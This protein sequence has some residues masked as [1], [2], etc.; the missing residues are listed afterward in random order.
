[1]VLPV[2]HAIMGAAH[3]AFMGEK[4]VAGRA[5]GCQRFGL[6]DGMVDS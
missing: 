3:V 5:H 2:G 6:A 4:L 1:M